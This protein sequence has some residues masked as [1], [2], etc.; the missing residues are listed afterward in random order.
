MSLGL[1]FIHALVQGDTT[2]PLRNVRDEFFVKDEKEAFRFV[3]AH[4]KRHGVL[5]SLDTLEENGHDVMR[6]REPADYYVGKLRER[7]IYTV[8]RSR[9][10]KIAK[11]MRAKEVSEAMAIIKEI[12][13]VG[14]HVLEPDSFSSLQIEGAE[15]LN[16]YY[17]IKESG[18]PDFGIPTPWPT[19]DRATMGFQNGDLIVLAARPNVGKT[20]LLLLLAYIAW[21]QGKSIGILS[22]E[23][24]KKQMV[25]RFVSFI[26]RTNPRLLREGSLS[27]WAEEML[28]G[29]VRGLRRRPPVWINSSEM[30][31]R[32]TN[33]VDKLFAEHCP[34][35]V[36]ID[37][38]Y[39]LVPADARY[40]MSTVDRNE[41]TV[42]ELKQ[43]AIHHDRPIVAVNQYNRSV[44]QRGQTQA[45]DLGT[46][47]GTDAWEQDSSIFLG[48][49]MGAAP[50]E[51][52]TRIIDITKNRD[53][54]T[55][56]FRINFCLDP[57][58]FSE[59]E[60]GGQFELAD[61]SGYQE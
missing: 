52:S 33:F 18:E 28:R 6:S 13:M 2:I 14:G 26:T 39:R 46:A 59:I 48:A 4:L 35:I 40:N 57:L 47:K 34:D 41:Q 1:Q 5:P 49:R 32:S 19:L 22:M 7:Y 25:R 31:N 24:T 12:A 8:I 54:P 50:F 60:D 38:A 16:D 3:K 30:K 29:A 56:E 45:A 42:N 11:H 61:D 17:R 43:L 21:T 20:W 27:T 10:E 37:S 51:T 23:M 9:S 58:D 53:G 15:L 44:K 55:G 36:F